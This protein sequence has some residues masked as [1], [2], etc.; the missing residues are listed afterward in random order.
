[1]NTT[2]LDDTLRDFSTGL[3][4]AATTF[5]EFSNQVELG[6]VQDIDGEPLKEAIIR[7]LGYLQDEAKKVLAAVRGIE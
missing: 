4:L 6:E 1:M 2:D 3:A 7:Q 5:E